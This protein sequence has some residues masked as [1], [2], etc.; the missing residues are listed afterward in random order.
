MKKE[1][2][3]KMIEPSRPELRPL[4]IVPVGSKEDV[5]FALRDPEGFGQTV[6]MPYG[7]ALLAMLMDGNHTLCEIQTEFQAETGTAAP[8]NDVE[9]IL[10]C[11]DD[12]YLLAGKRFDQHRQQQIEQYL[13]NPVRPASHAGGAY[14]DDPETLRA[15]LGK[16]FTCDEGPGAI[17]SKATCDGRQLRGIISPHIDLHRGGPAFAWSYKQ[18]VQHSDADLFVIFGTAHN[19]MEQLFCIS[20]KHFE[21]PLGLVRTD[22]V[23]VDRVAEHLASS[24]AG[25]QLDL[26]EDEMAHRVEHS[27]ELQAVFLQYV[28][29]GKRDFRIVPVLS[30]SFQEFLA[31]GLHPDESPHVQAFLAAIRSAADQ[32]PGKVC[33]IS[34][35]DFAHIGQRFG[36]E[37]LLDEQRLAEQSADDQKL[38]EAACRSDSAGFFS[39]VADQLDRRRICGLSPTY[40]MLKLIEPCCGELLKYAQAVEPDG[41][42]C[43]S[44]ASVAYYGKR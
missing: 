6:V 32:H 30:G 26:F 34:G 8:L 25:G 9:K 27:I 19:P 18:V 20:Q 44:F 1:E 31:D 29:G 14:A 43:V 13:N 17:D 28:L 33:Y 2:S 38:I 39:H 7:A 12:A 16:L 35:A 41:T 21:T 36:D 40:T 37:W 23:F 24:V 22:K 5:A 4:E 42:S 10:R 3:I 15:Q 11:L